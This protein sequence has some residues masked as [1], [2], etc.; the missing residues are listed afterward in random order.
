MEYQKNN[1]FVR[2]YTKSTTKFR[3]KNWIEINHDVCGT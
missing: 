2:Q 3:T 1:K